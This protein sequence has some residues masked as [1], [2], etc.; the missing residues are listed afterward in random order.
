MRYGLLKELKKSGGFV[1]GEEL[2]KKAGVTRAALW[3]HIKAM[4]D[5]GAVIESAP[6]RGYRLVSPPETPRAEYVRAYMCSN[7]EVVYKDSTGS[8]NE[9]AKQ[10]GRE[11]IINRGVFIAGEQTKG[12]GRKGRTWVSPPGGLYISLLVR[13]DMDSE[14]VP[15]MTLMAAVKLC[16]ALE[17]LT[18]AKTSIK[19]PNDVLIDGKKLAGILTESMVGMDGV[20]YV[21]C[22]MGINIDRLFEG[23][24][25]DKACSVSASRML[26]AAAV[27]DSFFEG[28]DLFLAEGIGAFLPDFRERS[29]V[30]GEITVSSPGSSF[31]GIFRGYDDT[32]AIIIGCGGEEKR[33]VAGEV[34][35]KGEG[36][37][38]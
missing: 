21:V 23:E 22:G 37:Y 6:G 32:G 1:S 7:A 30:S 14:K 9:D 17:K 11:G 26:L 27:A 18:G 38:V 8:T 25:K 4:E 12:K 35:L 31:T 10:G 3:K 34:S 20:E 15:G 13:P 2:A 19:W 29:A 28:Y 16:E 24:L 36:L 33:F 5:D